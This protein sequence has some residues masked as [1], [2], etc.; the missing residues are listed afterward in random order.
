[1]AD[2]VA[3]YFSYPQLPPLIA[4]E[5]TVSHGVSPGTIV[6]R[7]HP[8]TV[9]PVAV[10]DVVIGDGRKRLTVR[11][12]K[13]IRFTAER[14][15]SGNEWLIELEDSRWRWRDGRI[16]GRY[17][18]LDPHGKLIPRQI[19]SPTELAV[20]CLRAMGLARFVVDMPDGIPGAAF[21]NDIPDFLPV[22]VNF[23][24]IGLNPPVD[25]YAENPA[26][27]LAALAEQCGR[28]L[29]YDPVDDRVLVVRPGLGDDLPNGHIHNVTPSA[30]APETPDAVQIVGDPTRYETFF[31]LEAV[32]LEWDQSIKPIDQLSYAPTIEARQHIVIYEVGKVI[33]GE[34]YG[35]TIELQGRKDPFTFTYTAAG[36]DTAA[37]IVD[38]L[39]AQIQASE[40]APKLSAVT[41][42]DQLFVANKDLKILFDLIAANPSGGASV[43]IKQAGSLAR[44]GWD[45]SPPPLYPNIKATDRL[46]RLQAQAL[47]Q[48]GVFRMY[49]ITGRDASTLKA[50]IK[51]PGYGNAVRQDIILLDE[52]C[53]QVVPEAGDKRFVDKDGQPLIR[54]V[55]DGYSRSKPAEVYGSVCSACVGGAWF[56]GDGP[57]NAGAAAIG[58]LA[59]AEQR[60]MSFAVKDVDLVSGT[61]YN[62]TI[63][64][65]KDE[66]RTF[67]YIP[68]GSDTAQT[69]VDDLKT[70]LQASPIA[71]SLSVR[72]TTDKLFV[73]GR[74][75]DLFEFT[76]T[77]PN[78][79][80]AVST[81]KTGSGS[82]P[83]TAPAQVSP[84]Q[85]QKLTPPGDG[86]GS[87]LNTDPSDRVYV[88]FSVDSTWQM[89][90]FNEPV[91]FL[92]TG[93]A[94]KEPRLFLRAACNVRDA[95][96]Q[97]LVAYTDTRRFR[98]GAAVKIE[99]RPDVQLNVIG[100]YKIGL[101]KNGPKDAGPMPYVWRLRNT[102][103]LEQ[104]AVMRAR[105]YL[106]AALVQFQIKGG[107]TTEYNGIE[108]V[109]LDGKTA[110]VTYRVEG[111]VGTMTTASVNM[112]HSTWLP[113]YPARRRAENLAAV[114]RNAAIGA[115]VDNPGGSTSA[116]NGGT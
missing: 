102:R 91:W 106:I 28:R 73:G 87:S 34:S 32:G 109:R 93:G 20:L 63:T 101:L 112:E 75:G 49:R 113:P 110:Q 82:P 16:D 11:N 64:Y 71:A 80:A 68:S 70:Q 30:V 15:D 52:L 90:V 108:P 31:E 104:D 78:H 74:A 10:G 21:I 69:I 4:G 18:Q 9:A 25:W 44:R 51:I 22:G 67:F 23:P 94:V 103:L 55:Y 86:K 36:G 116:G 79:L 66:A 6:L 105:Y 114:A 17:N 42:T 37:T 107:I 84:S 111:G 62:V 98:P 96:T 47:A 59:P 3:G 50:P 26:S 115:R 7:T 40:L 38:D 60:I 54:T 39:K 24:A 8:G 45:F 89:I 95:K 77:T 46:T 29:V 27:V 72:T 33:A 85:A 19:K 1:M 57:V 5:Y 83:T 97:Q 58:K 65:P 81:V 14:D 76:T 41:T 92:G 53:E 2:V 12:C 56:I 35:V 99:K 13:L 48:K 88:D 100:E 61:S 43:R